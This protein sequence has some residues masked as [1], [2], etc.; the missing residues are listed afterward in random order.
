LPGVPSSRP[1]FGGLVLIADKSA[2]ERAADPRCAKPWRTALRGGQLAT[3]APAALEILFS[4]RDATDFAR[5]DDALS[6][7]REIPV[8][9]SITDAARTAM[10]ELAARGRH[11]LPLGDYLIAACAQAA[12]VGVLHHDRHFDVLAQVLHFDSVHILPGPT[13]AD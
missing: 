1:P 8:T 13:A 5:L 2:W 10:Q 6:V 3:C 11:R 4:A 12:G 7:L 9:R